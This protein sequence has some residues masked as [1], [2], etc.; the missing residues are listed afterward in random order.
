MKKLIS[1]FIL[2]IILTSC[3]KYNNING[4]LGSTVLDTIPIFDIENNLVYYKYKINVVG[5]KTGNIY[6]KT[7]KIRKENHYFAPGDIIS[8]EEPFNKAKKVEKTK[9]KET[10]TNFVE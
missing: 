8:F 5:S 1:I 9:K 4:Y 3:V 6:L 2:A 10:N 7:L